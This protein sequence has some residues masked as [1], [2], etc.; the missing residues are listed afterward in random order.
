MYITKYCDDPNNDVMLLYGDKKYEDSISEEYDSIISRLDRY[1]Y[2]VDAYTIILDCAHDILKTQQ[3]NSEMFWKVNKYLLNYVNAVFCYKEFIRNYKPELTDI[4]DDYWW[5]KNN[6]FWYR[7]I[8]EYRDRIVHQSIIVRHY[9]PPEG[10]LLVNIDELITKTKHDIVSGNVKFQNNAN[11]FVQQLERLARTPH[12][13]D[14]KKQRYWKLK[15]IIGFS[16][17]EIKDMSN[18][19]FER[20]YDDGINTAVE[21][22]LDHVYYEEYDGNEDKY[23]YIVNEEVPNS[24]CEPN[25]S[26]E[27]FFGKLV[28]NLGKEHPVCEKIRKLFLSKGYTH[29]CQGNCG[30]ETFMESC[31]ENKIIQ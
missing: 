13:I 26:L 19:I 30:I 5:C 15:K 20:A 25:Y 6:T 31:T 9:Y 23:T 21:W 3:K 27:W 17:K 7:F 14:R 1:I 18:Q 16:N 8:C 2:L 12:F 10:E 24:E 4:A 29:F 28:Q 22:L 11:F